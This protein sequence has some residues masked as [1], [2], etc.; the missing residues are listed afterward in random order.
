MQTASF[1]PLRR[2]GLLIHGLIL[3]ALLI[4][5]SWAFVN[6]GQAAIGPSVLIYLAILLITLP[7]LPFFA[8]RAFALLRAEYV[9]DRDRLALYWGLRIEDIPLNEIEW[10][11]P[12]AD[13][14][15]PLRPPTFSL[16]GALLGVTRHPDLPTPIEFLASERDRLL[17]VATA[18]RTYAIS[19]EDPAAFLAIFR[20]A[21]ELGSL[22][23][24]RAV[25]RYPSFL[26]LQAWA[27][28]ITRFLWTAGSLLNLGLIAW[29]V[30]LIP[31]VA[32]LPLGFSP[33]GRPLEAV[34]SVR[35]ILLPVLSVSLFAAGI[36]AGLYFFRLSK[37]RVLGILIWVSSTLT[38]LLFLVAV[39]FLVSA[40]AIY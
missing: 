10:V 6:L 23:P 14:K 26:L 1:P 20:R 28:P 13:L 21:M 12:A 15:P 9:L 17:L 40:P 4:V 38:S 24:A 39:W 34:P 35:L 16:P 31:S 37:Y 3:A 30:F 27:L 19:P 29:T 33:M 2:R 7:L 8:Y 18:R 11:R 32:R 36:L 22:H 25:S 5:T